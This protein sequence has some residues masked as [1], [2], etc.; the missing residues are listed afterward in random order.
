M[1]EVMHDKSPEG[2]ADYVEYFI[3]SS[4]KSISKAKISKLFP[5]IEEE[6]VDSVFGELENRNKLYG[7]C[8][9]ILLKRKIVKP[10]FNWKNAPELMLCLIFSLEG[11]KKKKGK[12]DGTKLFER[13]SKEVARNY[14]S[15]EAE[16][17]GFPADC[18]L[19]EHITK[20]C[21]KAY[22]VRG[23]RS[24]LATDKD[25]GV[26]I[27]AW[28]PHGDKRSNQV[29]M[30]LQC[31]AGIHYDSKLPISLTAWREFINWSVAPLKGIVLPSILSNE[32]WNK[33]RDNHDLIFD[34]V[35]I[36]RALHGKEF[37]SELK[38]QMIRWCSKKIKASS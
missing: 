7:N 25:V 22:E 16:V 26:D 5:D 18:N 28:K 38:K 32:D 9:P 30:L 24:P 10:N 33:V 12:D 15:G 27:I 6:V 36:H 23:S 3:I 14:L 19:K 34:R 1:I 8:S 4:G 13:L 11:V 37:D 2:I 29:I 35:R 31:A 20:I 21:K 17:I